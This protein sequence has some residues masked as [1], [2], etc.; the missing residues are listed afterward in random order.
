MVKKIKAED[1]KIYVEKKPFYKRVWF[2]VLA[3]LVVIGVFA[4][5][6]DSKK[7]TSTST[8]TRKAGTAY[9]SSKA[10]TIDSSSEVSSEKVETDYFVGQTFTVGDVEYTV[11]SVST[12]QTVGDEFI[13]ETAQGTYLLLNITVKNNGDNALS[14]SNDYFTLYKGKTKYTSDSKASLY[15][16][17]HTGFFLEEVNPGNALTGTVAFD[18]PQS[19]VLDPSLQLQV[20]TGF[21]GTQTALVNINK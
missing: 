7:A 1:G 12:S 8:I 11:N 19:V 4:D 14:V 3:I 20:Q 16:S 5:S 18:I 6:D 21:L 9:S 10:G 15:A 2:I 17:N 13:N